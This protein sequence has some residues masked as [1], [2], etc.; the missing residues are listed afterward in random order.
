MEGTEIHS[1]VERL[2]EKTTGLDPETIGYGKIGA[3][4]R[5]RMTACGLSSSS[6][7]G[8]LARAER[9]ELIHLIDEIVIPET[10]FFRDRGPFVLLEKYASDRRPA[11]YGDRPL[12]ALSLPCSTGEEPYSIAM[13]LLGAGLRPQQIHI[14]AVDISRRAIDAARRAL[15]RKNS[16]R[17]RNLGF[18]ERYFARAGGGYRLSAEVADLVSFYRG[19]IMDTLPRQLLEKYDVLFCRNLLIYFSRNA[20]SRVLA[21]IGQLLAEGG[22][23]F[24]GHAET[25]LFFERPE[26]AP[27]RHA[28]A[29]A[30]SRIAGSVPKTARQ[31]GLKRTT[32]TT[33]GKTGGRALKKKIPAAPAAEDFTPDGMRPG[34]MLQEAGRLADRGCLHEASE[35][36]TE[37]L[38]KHSTDGHAHY[39][40]GLIRQAQKN[41]NGAEECFS[42]AV[43]LNPGH[44]EAL[45]HLALLKE[46]RGDAAGASLLRRRAQRARAAKPDEGGKRVQ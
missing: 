20:R 15:Y 28:R 25:G 5:R 3:A 14:D 21:V 22:L 1:P 29:F 8:C 35:L 30:F 19:N 27:V 2:I 39:L 18:R 38:K 32:R 36:C 31:P 37:Y 46:H 43:Y 17:G 26:F 10:W 7:Y 11:G 44:Y 6:D 45:V 41:R 24:V 34:D 4:V 40:L 23:L 9:N 12:R 33:V 42:R 13:T 16:F